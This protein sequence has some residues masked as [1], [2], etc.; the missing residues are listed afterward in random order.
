MAITVLFQDIK[1]CFSPYL[2]FHTSLYKYILIN[3]TFSVKWGKK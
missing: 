1:F 3:E 2:V